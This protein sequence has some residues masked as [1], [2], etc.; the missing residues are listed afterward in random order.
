MIAATSAD[1]RPE[2]EAAG[3]RDPV[4]QRYRRLFAYLDW[5]VI[6]ERD[7]TKPRAGNLGHPCAAYVKALLVKICEELPYV[8]DL[9]RFLVEHPLLVRDLGFRPVLD[10]TQPFG[11][12][13]DATVPTDRWLRHQQQTLDPALLTALLAST[14]H[15]V[16]SHVPDLGE[17]IAVDV[18][19]LYAWVAENNPTADVAHRFDPQRR[20][21]GDPECRLGAKCRSNG[22]HAKVKEY[23]WGYGWGVAAATHPVCGDV[24]LAE[25][26]QPFNHQD[27]TVFHPVYAQA[28]AHLGR[29][30]TNVTTDAAFDAWHVYQTCAATGGIAAIA[31]NDRGSSPP[32]TPD[33]RPIC[34]QGLAMTPGR[35][36]RHED[37]FRAQDHHCPLL[38]PHRTGETCPQAQF[39]KGGCHKYV[40]LEPGGRM[41]A[42]LDRTSDAFQAVYR[43]RTCVERINSQAKARGLARPKV[44]RMAG[45]RR[46]STLTAIVINLGVLDRLQPHAAVPT[47]SLC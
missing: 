18:T 1:R 11:F 28:C 23:L 14:V 27:I 46:L 19:H 35:E 33:G 22:T 12:D 15:A 29:T 21:R 9:R 6:P 41:R 7:P 17:T 13:V 32:R 10:P 31:R 16:Q 36:F 34:A 45:V 2:W 44:R 8:T 30:P 25:L 24:V 5:R 43:Q 47:T 40:N 38:R 42:E 26:T 39:A 4:V 20:V 3:D 37:G